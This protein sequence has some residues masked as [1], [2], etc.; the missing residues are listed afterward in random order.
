MVQ[1]HS[2]LGAALAFV[3]ATGVLAHPGANIWEELEERE[4]HLKNPERRTMAQCN[5]KLERDGH[6]AQEISRR[7]ER[8]NS[9]RL[10]RGLD[11]SVGPLET[12]QRAQCILDPEV[13]E[14]PYCGF[15]L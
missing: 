14:G 1:L 13:T 15:N 9:L 5:S 2:S 6:Y 7:T 4:Q 11:A 10:K 8:I 3:M 12:R